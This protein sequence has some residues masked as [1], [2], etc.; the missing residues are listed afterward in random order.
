MNFKAWFP[1][2]YFETDN[3]VLIN[4]DCF[5]VFK[6]IPDKSI[7]MILADLPYGITDCKWDNML[8]LDKLWAEYRRIIKDNGVILLFGT[9]PFRKSGECEG[10]VIP[11]N[12]LRGYT[13]SLALVFTIVTRYVIIKMWG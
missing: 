8:P 7:N 4:D 3:G 1:N 13:D 5:N 2:I 12:L 10:A 6:N 9:E 11:L